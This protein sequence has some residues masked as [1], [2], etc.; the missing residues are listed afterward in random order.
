M[1]ILVIRQD[2]IGDLVLTTPVFTALR[3]RFPGARIEALVNSYNAPVMAGHPDVDRVHVYTKGKHRDGRR[4]RILELLLRAR[5]VLDLRARRFDYVIVAAP[6]FQPRQVRL[7]R[8]LNP[9]HIVAFVPPGKAVAGVDHPVEHDGPGDFHHLEDTFRIVG[10]LGIHGAPPAPRVGHGALPPPRARTPAVI[11]VH[12]ST[13][14]AGNR[15]PEEH[16]ARLLREL[17]ARTGA[18]LRLYWSPGESDDRRHPGDDER[19][20]RIIAA[21]GCAAVQPVATTRLDHLVAELAG[22]DLL[23]C[24]DGGAMHLAAA[25]GRPIVCFFG[26]SPA[27]Y[28]RPWGVPH[29][30]LQ[31]HSRSASDITVAEAVAACLELAASS[32]LAEAWDVRRA[33]AARIPESLPG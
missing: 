30:L 1:K 23:V 17:H 24:S 7:A 16:F 31:P 13:R 3:E 5:Q 11:G 33:V 19:A 32:G 4:G 18:T 15:W 20:R 22:C 2:N 8:W 26:I 14:K 9:R 29:R 12:V 21:A 28:W 25:L 10:P 27:S 6:G